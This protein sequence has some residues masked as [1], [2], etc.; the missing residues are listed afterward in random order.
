ML[1]P[2]PVLNPHFLWYFN[3]ICLEEC[4]PLG[5][6]TPIF[7]WFFFC[8]TGCSFCVSFPGSASSLTLNIIHFLGNLIQ[9]HGFKYLLYDDDIQNYISSSCLSLLNI[10]SIYPIPTD[11]SIWMSSKYHENNISKTEFLIFLPTKPVQPT[12][13]PISINRDSFSNFSGTRC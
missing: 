12:I 11:I 3:N 1:T 6:E 10:P 9:S 5:F 13:F 7:S 8:D 2:K 4:C